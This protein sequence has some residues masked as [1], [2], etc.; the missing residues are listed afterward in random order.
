MH[1]GGFQIVRKG[2]NI[3]F[4]WLFDSTVNLKHHEKL[5][6]VIGQKPLIHFSIAVFAL[7]INSF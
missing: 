3:N 7:K 2:K 4:N 6:T 5:F 1:P